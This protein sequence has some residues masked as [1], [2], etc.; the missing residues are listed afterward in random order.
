VHRGSSRSPLG[1]LRSLV[2][3]SGAIRY[4]RTS[5]QTPVWVTAQVL[6]AL[7]GKR[8]PLAPVPRARHTQ[9]AT[10]EPA[11]AATPQ[12]TA[13]P[14]PKPPKHKPVATVTGEANFGVAEM[15]LQPAWVPLTLVGSVFAAARPATALRAGY[16]TAIVARTWLPSPRT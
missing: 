4:S 9:A 7:A 8:L 15:E 2:G 14:A 11:P 3:S 13:T 5:A 10:T 6:T 12:P 16:V 1:Y